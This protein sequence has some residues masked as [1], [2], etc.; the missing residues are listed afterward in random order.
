MF[1]IPVQMTDTFIADQLKI[2]RTKEVFGEKMVSFYH[3]RPQPSAV[4]VALR[5]I[6]HFG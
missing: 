6:F 2:P 4:T 3:I 5:Q 1:A